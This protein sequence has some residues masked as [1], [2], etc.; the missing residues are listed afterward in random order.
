[1]LCFYYSRFNGSILPDLNPMRSSTCRCELEL[2]Y[3][4]FVMFS[5]IFKHGKKGSRGNREGMG[6]RECK[7]N[8]KNR[9]KC[10]DTQ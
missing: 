4:I 3:L 6:N 8:T 10:F 7:K 2:C 5:S 1:M 9:D